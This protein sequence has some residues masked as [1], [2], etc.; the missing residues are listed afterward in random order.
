MYYN[1]YK[2]FLFQ[3]NTVL[4]NF[5]LIKLSWKKYEAAELFSMIYIRMFSEESCDTKEWSNDAEYTALT[6]QD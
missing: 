1:C 3:T 4:L 5:L 6:S 2:I